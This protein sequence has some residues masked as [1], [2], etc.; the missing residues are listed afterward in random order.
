MDELKKM[1][2]ESAQT[3]KIELGHEK[4][5]VSTYHELKA[6]QQLYVQSYCQCNN[7]NLIHVNKQLI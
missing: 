6:C 2:I 1:G 5:S 7:R 4:K 3:E